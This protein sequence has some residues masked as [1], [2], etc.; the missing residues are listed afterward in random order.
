MNVDK[1]QSLILTFLGGGN[2]ARALIAGLSASKHLAESPYTLRV[3]DRNQNKLAAISEEYGNFINIETFEAA[4]DA[5]QDAD[6]VVLATKPQGLLTLLD[7]HKSMLSTK[8]LLVSV[9]AGVTVAS[10]QGASGCQ[11]VVRAMPNTPAVVGKGATGL[12]AADEVDTYHRTLAEAIFAD[13]GVCL[14]VKEEALLAA[15]TAVSGSGPA[16]FFQIAEHMARSGER[17]GLDYDDA[18][19]LA[20]QTMRG[21][22]SM[23]TSAAHER[24]AISPTRLRDQVTSKGGTTEQALLSFEENRLGEII[25][26]AMAACAQRADEL[27]KI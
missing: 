12:Y 16:Y 8:C 19:M 4:P 23:I 9:A 21:A 27:A 15:V 24:P 5:L 3:C 7:E 22:A 6:I 10:I 13:S 1:N 25:D 11:R 26:A 17:L 14:W 2:M 18:L 20:T